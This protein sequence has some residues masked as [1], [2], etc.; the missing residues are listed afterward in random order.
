MRKLC[1]RLLFPFWLG[2]FFSN[3][4]YTQ[5]DFHRMLN[6]FV[7][8]TYNITTALQKDLGKDELLGNGIKLNSFTELFGLGYYSIKASGMVWGGS[9]YIYRV[10]SRAVNGSA[11]LKAANGFFNMGYC[12]VKT[13]RWIGFP[14]VGIGLAAMN[15][16]ITNTD[17]HKD[18]ILYKDTISAGRSARYQAG[19]VALDFGFSLKFN[20][21]GAGSATRKRLHPIIGVDIGGS[22]FPSFEYW[23]SQSRH[24][25]VLPLSSPFLIAPYLRVGIGIGR[26]C[27]RPVAKSY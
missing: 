14:Y 12:V 17:E 13:D 5:S 1:Y 18:I 27:A 16:G 23:L 20:K 19:G 3:A 22:L 6:L 2:M 15:F 8:E 11:N 7:G 24:D 21:Q 10:H 4:A 25:T 26:N 9:G